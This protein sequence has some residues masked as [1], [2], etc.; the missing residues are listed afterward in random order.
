[1][2]AVIASELV[3]AFIRTKLMRAAGFDIS[4]DA[5]IWPQGTFRS[6][7]IVIGTG[8]F[9]NIGFYHDGYDMLRIGNNVR[10]GAFVR[11]VTATHDIGPPEQRGLI[12]VV[13]RPVTIG[14][15]CWIGTGSMILPGVTLSRGCVLGANAML[16]K[17]TE[18]DGL[19][20]GNPARR[21][22][23]L[24]GGRSEKHIGEALMQP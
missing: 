22:R 2:G 16:A 23:D 7:R 5:C 21:M 8:V 24:E 6:K 19:Y 3:P 1:M 15:G 4:A 14:D 17:S 13:G 10:I 12:E 9:I 18:P 20:A 11:V